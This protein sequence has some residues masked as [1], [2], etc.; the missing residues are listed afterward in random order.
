MNANHTDGRDGI[1]PQDFRLSRIRTP[2][3]TRASV[4][5]IVG[6]YFLFGVILFGVFTLAEPAR[7]APQTRLGHDP[8]LVILDLTPG[9]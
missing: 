3:A 8:G 7:T 2:R 1:S 4:T 6:T 5:L 9:R